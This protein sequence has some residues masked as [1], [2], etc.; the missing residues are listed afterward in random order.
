MK[1][2]LIVRQLFQLKHDGF[3]VLLSLDMITLGLCLV[4]RLVDNVFALGLDRGIG[5]FDEV[6]VSLLRI[7]FRADGLGL[8]RLSIVDDLLDHTHDAA[9][10]CVLLIAIEAWWRW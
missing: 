4:L 8:H 2:R 3:L 1:F 7:F 10:S 5:L 6:L 9:R